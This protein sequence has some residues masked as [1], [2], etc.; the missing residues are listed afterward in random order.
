MMKTVMENLVE[1]V[2][3]AK[4]VGE[5]VETPDGQVIIPVSR[6]SF[7]FVTGGS[8]FSDDNIS[9]NKSEGNLP[10]GG[11]AGAGVSLHPIAFL[12]VGG[13]EVRLLPVDQ[14]APWDRLL[15]LAPQIVSQ[16]QGL[17]VN[18]K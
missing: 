12:V 17:M 1:M 11:G 10:F 18:N 2:D 4:I 7:G 16:L 13:K 15:D 5:A 9:E 14:N 6:V 8:E 3:V